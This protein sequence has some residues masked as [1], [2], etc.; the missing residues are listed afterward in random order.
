MAVQPI[1]IC[2]SLPEIQAAMRARADALQLSRET[3][4]GLSGLASG[5]SS[6]LLSPN[7]SR[8]LG[9][10]SFPLMLGA[11]GL[12]IALV[13]AQENIQ[14]IGALPPRTE[15]NAGNGASRGRCAWALALL[16][17]Q[18]GRKAMSLLTPDQ[19]RKKQS[20][21]AK[22]RW[23]QWRRER[24]LAKRHDAL[25]NERKMTMSENRVR[26]IARRIF[27]D[28]GD[29]SAAV[30]LSQVVNAEPEIGEREIKAFIRQQGYPKGL[31]TEQA[32]AFSYRLACA[33]LQFGRAMV[34]GFPC[35]IA[36]DVVLPPA[37]SAHRPAKGEAA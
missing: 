21:A 18:G 7:P 4:D 15:V 30:R 27:S 24:R 29:L 9:Q 36:D 26:S 20:H 32:A 1:A 31:T 13:D 37:P 34:D 22:A 6:K 8:R 11:L 35:E 33:A 10:V 16:G 14:P 25:G 12:S 3:I 19:L 5:Y 23:R 17:R 28:A 2:R